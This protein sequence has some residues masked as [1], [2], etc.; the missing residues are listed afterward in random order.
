MSYR[1]RFPPRKLFDL[2]D[3]RIGLSRD[4]LRVRMGSISLFKPPASW[5]V[6]GLP[7]LIGSWAT[8]HS[9]TNDVKGNSDENQMQVTT[10]ARATLASGS[11]ILMKTIPESFISS[12]ATEWGSQRYHLMKRKARRRPIWKRVLRYLFQ[13]VAATWSSS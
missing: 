2:V 8:D 6:A 11:P 5:S 1:Q 13:K 10:H 7:S 9:S 4:Q 12:Q 3:G